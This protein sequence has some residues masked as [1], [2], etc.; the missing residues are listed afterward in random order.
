[1]W[2]PSKTMLRCPN[3]TNNYPKGNKRKRKAPLVSFIIPNHAR[4][5]K[6]SLTIDNIQ[7]EF[8]P[9]SKKKI[10]TLVKKHLPVKCIGGHIYVE[11]AALENLISDPDREFFSLN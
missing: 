2:S 10:R 1:M 11:R 4:D 9:I 5:T 3:K 8:L 6:V 7:K